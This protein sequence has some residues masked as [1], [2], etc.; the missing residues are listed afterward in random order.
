MHLYEKV[1]FLRNGGMKLDRIAARL[2]IPIG[3]IRS[4]EQHAKRKGLIESVEIWRK[5]I[6]NRFRLNF[7]TMT[8]VMEGLSP[9][10]REW[11]VDQC[12]GDM[13]LADAVAAIV[14]DAY[15]EEL[16]AGQKAA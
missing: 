10:C 4:A 6:H 9:E 8:T 1:A 3:K 12:S 15:N 11:L 13:K 7:G 16:D 5:S 2:D 14:T